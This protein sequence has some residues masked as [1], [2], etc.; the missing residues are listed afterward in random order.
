MDD[1]AAESGGKAGGVGV[2]VGPPLAAWLMSSG[3]APL[4]FLLSALALVG[5]GLAFWL[6]HPEMDGGKENESGDI[7]RH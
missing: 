6:I 4:L 3:V 7:S 1:A 2:A 5:G